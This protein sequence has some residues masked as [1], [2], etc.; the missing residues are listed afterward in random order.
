M[1]YQHDW[2]SLV[3]VS[4]LLVSEPVLAEHFTAGWKTLPD[5]LARR[6]RTEYERV[7]SSKSDDHARNRW[8]NFVLR[9]LLAFKEE[10]LRGSMTLPPQL[11][12]HLSDY[13]QKLKPDRAVVDANG[14][15]ILLISIAADLLDRPETMTGRWKAS[16][17]TKFD[18]LL[19][20]T[21]VPLGL[22][23]NDEQWRLVYAATGVTT[24]YIE[25]SA[26]TWLDERATLNA[27]CALL[28][29]PVA[30]AQ[31][32]A[33]SQNR[34]ADVTEQLGSQ[35]LRAM[36]TLV[37]ELDHVKSEGQHDVLADM[38]DR[39]I[40]E[41]AL[42]VMMR[43]VFMFY[44]EENRL[45][46]HGEV[47]Y[48]RGYGITGLWNRLN[49]DSSYDRDHLA[50]TIDA[51]PQLLASFR[52]IYEG[53]DHPDLNMPAYG[54]D[55]FDPS[56]YDVLNNLRIR[57]H[58][59]W[60]MLR[61]LVTVDSTEGRQ[62][63]S[64]RTLNVEQLGST[65]ERLLDHV[66]VWATE[67]VLGLTGTRRKEPEVPLWVLEDEAAKGWEHLLEFLKDETGKT[68][69]SLAHTLDPDAM[70]DPTKLNKLR[71]L[72]S[73][74][75][76]PD[77]LF[78]RV[79]P[80]ANL[81]RTDDFGD[82]VLI[83]SGHL[84]VTAGPTRRATGTHY[85]PRTLTE[86]IVK[87]TLD[88]L[89]YVGM[90]EGKPSNEWR[91][92]APAEI[93]ALKICDMAMG[94]GAFLVQACR[95]LADKL[96]EA[97]ITAAHGDPRYIDTNGNPTR[98]TP[99]A[100]PVP[101]DAEERALLA[102]RLI[103]DR[104]LYGV[105]KNPLA[106]EMAKLSLWLVTLDKHRPFTFLDHALKAGDSLV[107]VSLEQLRHWRLDVEDQKSAPL[108]ALTFRNLIDEMV[109][110]R[111]RIAQHPNDTLE[112]QRYK[113]EQLR[114]AERIGHSLRVAADDLILS[115]F[116]DFAT[117]DQAYLREVLL[118]AHNNGS[119]VPEEYRHLRLPEDLR[120]FHWELEFPEVF[121][122]PGRGGF[123]AFIG[124]PPF[125]GGKKITGEFGVPY[126]EYLVNSLAGGTKGNADIVAYFYLRAFEHLRPDGSF[127]LIA[128][129]TIAQGDTRE[130]GLDKVAA[131][132][133][134]I[135][136]ASNNRQWPGQAAVY[137]N[138]THIRKGAYPAARILDGEAVDYISPLLDAMQ[139]QG[140]P[141]R[142]AANANKSFIGSYVLGMGFVL[143]PDEAQALI[144][145]DPRNADVLFPYLNGEDLNS[146]PDQSPSR[147]VI[148]FFD[149]PLEK[150][151]E[152]PDCMAIVRERVKPERQRRDENGEYA[153]RDPLPHKWW[154][155]ADKRPALYRTIAP[156]QRV[157]VVALTSKYLCFSF[158]RADWVY[159][160]ACGVIASSQDGYFAILQ[161]SYHDLWAR[162]KGSTLETRLR[163]TPADVFE[164]FPFP[165]VPISNEDIGDIYHKTR[166]N[167]ML[168]RW[169]G[170]TDTYNRFHA[171]AET[172]A[173]IENLRR[174]HVEMDYAVASAY[175]WSDLELGHAFHDTK[176]GMRFTIHESARRTVLTRLLELNHARHA[177]EVAAESQDRESKTRAKAGKS[178]RGKKAITQSDNQTSFMDD[179][180]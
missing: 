174:L 176:Q 120:P 144:D 59:V 56:R 161:S 73:E 168:D 117:R 48:D 58:A 155:Y 118:N 154:I 32:A 27:F 116:N 74:A 35:V 134:T 8:V 43:L 10:Q 57:N 104:C 67:P 45:L 136:H 7:T 36:S 138:I 123:D 169:E 86:P 139:T 125:M 99:Q 111:T 76:D 179:E 151:E 113:I 4:G 127:G 53:C 71:E 124:N 160:H 15:P 142:L 91:L 85:T 29:D 152:Y 130:V 171:P 40:Y 26:A 87:H 79:R 128:T 162:N 158:T 77:S 25:W 100:I 141:Y 51:W 55:L 20:E 5:W 28:H 1:A 39:Q 22:L 105:D 175:G 12:I 145:K 33:E 2:L 95:Y 3:D 180:E 69:K 47:L 114:Q 148:N 129:N 146:R 21:G 126:R 19:R 6:F 34:Q 163:Y 112:D 98:E 172:A 167:I 84:Y 156:L 75:D 96:V 173:D 165:N 133:G 23:T 170:L 106:V 38:T 108:L 78:E 94:S 83:L 24:A 17:F 63:V 66:A 149:W 140:N 81:I 101:T 88:P 92:L 89:L 102:R 147:W 137:V 49:K 159:A 52:L 121:S 60:N 122:L 50:E 68:L 65:Y 131:S 153:L 157:L 90:A 135:Y 61:H 16:P 109:Q 178:K 14:Q 177:E 107:G 143:T 110:L 80:Y 150:A 37:T 44:A 54:G 46:P 42:F 64:Y 82:P 31:L 41:M 103:A 70:P 119:D 93:L 11:E 72:S 62:R 97:W 30:L 115:Y 164:T 9:D 13:L 18:R 166:R 132:N